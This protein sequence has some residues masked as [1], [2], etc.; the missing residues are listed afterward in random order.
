MSMTE[1]SAPQPYENM[2]VGTFTVAQLNSQYPS[3]DLSM[4]GRYAYVSDRPG[5]AGFMVCD[6]ALGWVN[7][8]KRI[9]TYSGTT[10]ASGNY[11]VVFATPFTAAPH[12]NPVTFPAADSTTRVRVTAASTT[13]FTVKTEKNPSIDVLG[14]AVLQ[15]GTANVASVPVR[16]L[17]IES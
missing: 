17:V 2:I 9:E 10:D 14:I 8:L 12:V 4:A 11:T 1:T 5:G 15:V 6:P 16:V 13:G 7:V 3:S